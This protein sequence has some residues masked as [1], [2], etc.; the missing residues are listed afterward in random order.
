M[1]GDR[2]GMIVP[3]EHEG[4][5]RNLDLPDHI[6]YVD[7]EAGIVLY[8][9]D[10]LDPEVIIRK[11]R[12]GDE[13][14]MAEFLGKGAPKPTSPEGATVQVLRDAAG[15]E[16]NA[17]VAGPKTEGVVKATL[18]S[19]AT[20]PG[21]VVAKE[22]PQETLAK[23]VEPTMEEMDKS[24]FDQE[25]PFLLKD[26]QKGL[27]DFPETLSNVLAKVSGIEHD[28]SRPFESINE[29]V[30]RTRDALSEE[31][32]KA[33]K[34]L[35]A[36]NAS[37]KES[38]GTVHSDDSWSTF[39]ALDKKKQ[40][41]ATLLHDLDRA[42]LKILEQDAKDGLAAI[43]KRNAEA[44]RRQAIEA[45][46]G[47]P[48]QKPESPAL[49]AG[50]MVTVQAAKKFLGQTASVVGRTFDW[51]AKK[52]H[53]QPV[54]ESIRRSLGQVGEDIV[55]KDAQLRMDAVRYFNMAK[56]NYVNAFKGLTAEETR[57]VDLAANWASDHDSMPFTLT[58]RELAALDDIRAGIR[59]LAHVQKI[60]GGPGVKEGYDTYREM[61][62]RENYV[63][64][65]MKKGF[66][67]DLIES[68]SSDPARYE[69]HHQEWLDYAENKL[70]GDREKAEEIWKALTD[71]NNTFGASPATPAYKALRVQEGIGVPPSWRMPLKDALDYHAL[72]A[73]T[74]LS[75]YKHIQSDP[76]I[77]KVLGLNAD[78]GWGQPHPDVP[79]VNNEGGRQDIQDLI[80][81]WDRVRKSRTD[82]LQ[83]LTSFVLSNQLGLSASLRDFTTTLTNSLVESKGLGVARMAKSIA[84]AFGGSKSAFEG[85]AL[86]RRDSA[87]PDSQFIVGS[88]FNDW[89]ERLRTWTGRTAIQNFLETSTYNYGKA[90]G[91]KLLGDLTS[92]DKAAQSF[93]V[94]QLD[95]MLGT[96]WKNTF[97]RD[98]KQI[99]DLFAFKF[100]ESMSGSHRAADLSR[101]MLPASK[102]GGGWETMRGL[103][104][105]SRWSVGRMNNW[106]KHVW[107]AM[108]DGNPVPFIKSIVGGVL[109]AEAVEQ[110]KEW[111]TGQKPPEMSWKEFVNSGFDDAA[112]TIAG[113]LQ[114]T[115]G[116]G[117]LGDAMW[118]IAQA[119]KGELKYSQLN[120]PAIATVTRTLTRMMQGA[121]AI[122][123]GR[124]PVELLAEL[125][126]Q[127]ILDNNQ[128]LR[129]I[130][131]RANYDETGDT[132]R[133]E[134]QLYNRAIG[135]KPFISEV[136]P[137]LASTKIK[138]ASNMRD[139]AKYADALKDEI[140]TTAVVPELKSAIR[141]PQVYNYMSTLQG[142]RAAQAQQERDVQRE[143]LNRQKEM[144]F[145]QQAQRARQ[146]VSMET[147]KKW[148][149]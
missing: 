123:K 36:F 60:N 21:D 5:L 8:D 62:M 75:Y 142:P 20:Q 48:V 25:Y 94:K 56:E 49:G 11:V 141:Q 45:A 91:K 133:R 71:V 26:L 44:S 85:G 69:R 51:M 107:G 57:R 128:N 118:T 38:G 136:N 148:G 3:H 78:N 23:R 29:V 16:L 53:V 145:R 137:F 143:Y 114:L 135:R 146:E 15:H 52:A 41:I 40:D 108:E 144:L 17:A 139:A 42:R 24:I 64:N 97:I 28:P 149:Y 119:R 13:A 67:K 54:L 12:D 93:A 2:E 84:E 105:L 87:S 58:A 50:P 95:R 132:G 98:P 39:H 111:L 14:F 70:G 117:L 30:K 103:T 22:A 121:E 129:M 83:A 46:T 37:I 104:T 96:E 66:L 43:A 47:K 7:T 33:S 134:E 110:L 109:S 130:K 115:S 18:E 124:S 82:E 138:R 35:D 120:N 112:Y 72:R 27:K 59:A 61:M 140:A 73:S 4:S 76:R 102:L 19:Q 90:Y 122:D 74:D 100:R 77:S 79:E 125:P 113:K 147:R 86:Q 116:L 127:I 81:D 68:R 31:L 9:E 99:E 106:R 92:G 131:Q 80:A 34:E 88:L 101:E 6:K 10:K 63:P 55:M 126:M 65:A 1:N 32:S 89:A